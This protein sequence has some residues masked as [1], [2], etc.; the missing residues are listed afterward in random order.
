MN[1]FPSDTNDRIKTINI[2][3]TIQATNNYTDYYAKFIIMDTVCTNPSIT[4]WFEDTDF[5]GPGK[6]LRIYYQTQLIEICGSNIETCGDYKYCLN[7]YPLSNT[8]YQI[9]DGE[10]IT[11]H[12]QKGINSSIPVGCQYSLYADITL[13][14]NANRCNYL[15][16]V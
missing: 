4:I 13:E 12:L 6:F 7:R 15:W 11:I 10:Q 8:L 1:V 2:R 14:C 16:L 9:Q 3:S 5:H